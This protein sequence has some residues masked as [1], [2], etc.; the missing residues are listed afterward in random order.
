MPAPFRHPWEPRPSATNPR[1]F[2]SARPSVK[3]GPNP[4]QERSAAAAAAAA[5]PLSNRY[6]AFSADTTPPPQGQNPELQLAI[7]QI[8]RAL[9]AAA[10]PRGREEGVLPPSDR[11]TLHGSQRAASVR[12]IVFLRLLRAEAPGEANVTLAQFAATLRP[13]AALLPERSAAVVFLRAPVVQ[14]LWRLADSGNVSSLLRTVTPLP[15]AVSS[16]AAASPPAKAIA[17]AAASLIEAAPMIGPF[18]PYGRGERKVALPAQSS[19]PRPMRYPSCKSTVLVP[20]EFPPSL[21]TRSASLPAAMLEKVGLYTVS[22]TLLELT[23]LE[24]GST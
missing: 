10:A 3:A 2:A 5:A 20:P 1:A 15:P 24:L 8:N 14:A 6:G 17:A 19:L 23:L 11:I 7:A 9:G 18:D 16:A 12:E 22:L 13:L 21:I 4:R